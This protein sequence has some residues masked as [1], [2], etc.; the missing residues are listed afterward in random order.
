MVGEV[1]GKIDI[2]P[3]NPTFEK[4]AEKLEKK[5]KSM[6]KTIFLVSKLLALFEQEK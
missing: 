6:R 2:P 3:S 4:I 5:D 1:I